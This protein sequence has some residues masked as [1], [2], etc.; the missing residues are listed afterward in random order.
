MNVSDERRRADQP[1][2]SCE[3]SMCELGQLVISLTVR[4]RVSNSGRCRRTIPPA[5]AGY[6]ARASASALD[7]QGHLGGRPH[8]T[9]NY[10]DA[11]L[12]NS[13]EANKLVWKFTQ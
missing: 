5:P 13:R 10:F 6:L 7:A 4:A 1:G 12:A 8:K 9:I 3:M 11:L 2:Q